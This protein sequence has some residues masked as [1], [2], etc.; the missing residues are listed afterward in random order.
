MI[1]LPL[2]SI[3][4]MLASPPPVLDARAAPA[5][6]GPQKEGSKDPLAGIDL[7]PP[8]RSKTRL[9][10]FSLDGDIRADPVRK[11]LSELSTKDAECHV[12]YGPVSSAARPNK[13]FVAV[14][15]PVEKP[16]RD[17]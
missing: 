12:A 2:A 6:L 9:L 14:E 11:A 4:P 3:L 10:F 1:I 17:V 5:C 8:Q 7:Y 16:A 13:S 15:A